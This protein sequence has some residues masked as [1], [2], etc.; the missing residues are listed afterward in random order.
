MVVF[1]P[2]VIYKHTLTLNYIG[3]KK[4]L[5]AI[6]R[7]GGGTIMVRTQALVTN[8]CDAWLN[9]SIASPPPLNRIRVLNYCF[10]PFFL[11]FSIQGFW[12]CFFVIR[13]VK[14]PEHFF[15]GFS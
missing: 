8:I 6:L 5:Y 4:Y 10:T 9:M 7:E 15:A 2:Q 12:A 1:S 3:L 13:S 14:D 11:A